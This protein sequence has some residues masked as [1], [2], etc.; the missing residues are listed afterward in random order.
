MLHTYICFA[1]SKSRQHLLGL[2]TCLYLDSLGTQFKSVGFDRL[3]MEVA[4]FTTF[5][6]LR[7][8]VFVN[9]CLYCFASYF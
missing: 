1:I 9:R 5:S 2:G 3:N 8:F 6:Y 7:R 4:S